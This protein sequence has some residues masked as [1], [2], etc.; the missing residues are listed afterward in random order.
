MRLRQH[1]H[2]G[3]AAQTKPTFQPVRL[4]ILPAEPIFTRALAHALERQ[5]RPVAAAVED[6]VLP[7]LVGDRDG[8]EAAAEIG[9]Q[10][11]ILVREDRRR[12]VERVVE[13]HRLGLGREGL[14]QRLLGQPEMRR[15][16]GDEARHAA[17]EPHQRQ[18]GVVHGLEQHHLVAGLDDAEDRA[19]QRLRRARGHHHLAW[20]HR[21]RRPASACNGR[22]W[23]CAA[24]GCP[25]SRDTGCSR[26]A[27]PRPPPAARPPGPGSSG[28]PWP[29]LIAPVSRARLDITSKTVVGRLAKRR[30]H[31]ALLVGLSW[32]ADVLRIMERGRSNRH[33]GG[34]L[35]RACGSLGPT[36]ASGGFPPREDGGY[37]P[38]LPG[39]RSGAREPSRLTVKDE[40]QRMPPLCSFYRRG[41]GSPPARG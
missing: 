25:S 26:R 28:K 6:H 31:A 12:R 16:Q 21:G 27:P 38:V 18:V 33:S 24:P 4:K 22:R 17:G 39:P 20:S 23:P 34:A 9:E 36:N 37:A 40:S 8:V 10:R 15:L 41:Y 35:C 5:H 1:L 2:D 11:Q 3:G 29:R 14:G 19:R 32:G 7:D 13:H 30:V